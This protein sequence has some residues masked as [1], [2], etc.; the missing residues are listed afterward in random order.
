MM[1]CARSLM[2]EGRYHYPDDDAFII[3]GGA[4]ARLMELDLS[5][6]HSTVKPQKLLKK[7]AALRRKSLRASGERIQRWLNKAQR[8]RTVQGY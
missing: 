5:I 3:A 4:G 1:L 6:H 8:S 7:M 2:Q